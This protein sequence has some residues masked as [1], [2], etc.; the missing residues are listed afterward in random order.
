MATKAA[1]RKATKSKSKARPKDKEKGIV[2]GKRKCRKCGKWK[3]VGGKNPQFYKDTNDDGYRRY[4][5]P[6]EIKMNAKYKANAAKRKSAK[7]KGKGKRN[8]KTAKRKPSNAAYMKG[9]AGPRRRATA[10]PKRMTA[11]MSNTGLL[12]S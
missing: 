8:G 6:C 2:N 7:A 5:R 3:P 12:P 9:K 1:K 11:A 4:C 10:K